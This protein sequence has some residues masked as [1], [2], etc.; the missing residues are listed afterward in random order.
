MP[1]GRVGGNGGLQWQRRAGKPA[2]ETGARKLPKIKR[3]EAG[4]TCLSY[5]K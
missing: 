1:G 3:D 4:M 2:G 5:W